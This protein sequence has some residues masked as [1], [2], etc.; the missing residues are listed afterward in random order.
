MLIKPI[1]QGRSSEI[2]AQEVTL[3]LRGSKRP[4]RLG[5]QNRKF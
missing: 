1:A 2:N 4:V 5:A 3:W